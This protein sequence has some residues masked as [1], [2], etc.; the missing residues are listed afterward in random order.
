MVCPC[1]AE[2]EESSSAFASSSATD[3]GSSDSWSAEV[4]PAACSLGISTASVARLRSETTSEPRTSDLG[5]A[6]WTSS[7]RAGRARASAPRAAVDRPIR[8]SGPRSAE[9]STS[10]APVGSSSRTSTPPRGPWCNRISRRSDSVSLG[11]AFAR[12][13]SALPI[14]ARA[15]FY[16]PTPT[17]KA[18]HWAPSMRKW[19]AYR[20]LQDAIPHPSPELFE[21]MMGLPDGWISSGSPAKG[22]FRLWLR[23]HGARSR[24]GSADSRL[25]RIARQEITR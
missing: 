16:W 17:A 14:A 9:P 22:A 3:T 15:R 12:L 19:P 23:L 1:A 25:T 13:L 6:A 24:G 2:S 5:V 10:A 20:R 21:W 8:T 7:L 4:T 18:N 11:S